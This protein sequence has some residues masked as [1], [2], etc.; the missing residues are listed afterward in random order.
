[1]QRPALRHWQD[2]LTS[3]APVPRRRTHTGG[4]A[5]FRPRTLLLAIVVLLALSAAPVAAQ[6]GADC[7]DVDGFQVCGQFRAFVEANGDGAMLGNAL[8]EQFPDTRLD[9]GI[10]LPVQYFEGGRLELHPE[11]GGGP[12]GVQLGRLCAEVMG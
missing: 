12:F 2:R 11:N 6:P 1:G 3:L 4:L 5:M 7:R 9:T 10:D 8:S